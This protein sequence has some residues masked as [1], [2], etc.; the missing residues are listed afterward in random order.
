MICLPRRRAWSC[1]GC[2]SFDVL[3][4]GIST[5]FRGGFLTDNDSSVAR[6]AGIQPALI[7]TL[8][9]MAVCVLFIVPVGVATAVYLEEYAD[10]TRWFNRFIELNIQNLAG[11][12][13]DHLRH[14]RAGV[15]R[16]RPARAS[17]AWCWPAGSPS[18]CWCCPW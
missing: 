1:S 11:G 16:S 3:Q 12:A 17:A 2:C 10:R 7:G 14:P 4:E 9:L 6:D 18:G 15:P 5:L 8:Y 13:L